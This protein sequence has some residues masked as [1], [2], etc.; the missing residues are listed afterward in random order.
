MR[1]RLIQYA[2]NC[3]DGGIDA[4]GDME[5]LPLFPVCLASLFFLPPSIIALSP[6]ANRF[7]RQ[8]GGWQDLFILN[9][10]L[11]YFLFFIF[12]SP[13]YGLFQWSGMV[14]YFRRSHACGPYWFNG[15]RRRRKVRGKRDKREG[16]R[17]R[18]RKSDLA[19]INGRYDGRRYCS[20]LGSI[21]GIVK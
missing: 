16:R 8:A 2:E 5:F 15:R 6:L 10:G 12:V 18:G 3:E 7:R 13:L 20:P 14:S 17:E 19:M 1:R 11:A 4:G 21:C 9:E